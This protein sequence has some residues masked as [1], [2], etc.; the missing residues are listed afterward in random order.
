MSDFTKVFELLGGVRDELESLVRARVDEA[1]RKL[2]LVRREEFEAVQEVA[3]RARE[4]AGAA[5][6]RLAALELRVTALEAGG[7][8]L[9]PNSG[10]AG[11]L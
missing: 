9:P 7:I 6:S 4:Q 2:Q 1:L 5:E 3:T 10:L 11:D 8:N